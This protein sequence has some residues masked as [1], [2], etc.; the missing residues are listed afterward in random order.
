M[1]IEFGATKSI[2]AFCLRS[3]IRVSFLKV[4]SLNSLQKSDTEFLS[5]YNLVRDMGKFQSFQDSLISSIDFL[6]D[7]LTQSDIKKF[8]NNSNKLFSNESL[9]NISEEIIKVVV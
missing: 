4:K 9:K 5:K 3:A 6:D 8:E 2:K 7:H 1:A